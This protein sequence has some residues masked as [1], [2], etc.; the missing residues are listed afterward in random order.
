MEQPQ[1]NLFND[2]AAQTAQNQ[3]PLTIEVNPIEEALNAAADIAEQ[4]RINARATLA[5]K[6][7]TVN[8]SEAT[9]KFFFDVEKFEKMWNYICKEEE[10]TEE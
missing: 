9:P 10:N 3:E 5:A 1:K 7:V 2:D 6:F 4:I 8:N